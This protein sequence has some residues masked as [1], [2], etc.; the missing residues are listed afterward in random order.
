MELPVGPEMLL[1]KF[2][3]CH[4]LGQCLHDFSQTI[5][6]EKMLAASSESEYAVDHEA[7]PTTQKNG[8]AVPPLRRIA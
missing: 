1:D 2:A 5:N 4:W 7:I 6:Q 3:G 8:Q